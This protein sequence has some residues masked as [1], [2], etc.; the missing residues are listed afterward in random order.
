MGWSLQC[1]EEGARCEPIPVRS[2]QSSRMAEKGMDPACVSIALEDTV[3]HAGPPDAPLLTT[4]LKKVENHITE[5]QRFSHLPKR[6][7]VNI[8]FIDLSYSVREGSWWRKRGRSWRVGKGREG[9]A[10]AGLSHPIPILHAMISPCWGVPWHPPGSL[11]PVFCSWCPWQE[12]ARLVSRRIAACLCCAIP[13]Q[14][15]G[16]SPIPGKPL[17]RAGVQ[18]GAGWIPQ[19]CCLGCDGCVGCSRRPQGWPSSEAGKEKVWFVG[20]FLSLCSP[21]RGSL[22]CV[23]GKGRGEADGGWWVVVCFN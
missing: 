21:G 14:G 11:W 23:Q 17:A 20:G 5:A 12:E 8:E 7:A 18:G 3:C 19:P 6:S 1:L 22:P 13:G 16:T 10:P 9:R 4:H 2:P 15:W